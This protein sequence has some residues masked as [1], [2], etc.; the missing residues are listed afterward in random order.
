VKEQLNV[1]LSSGN[2]P[3]VIIAETL[4]YGDMVYYAGQGIFTALDPYD[5]LGYPNIKAA[6]D[7]YPALQQKT[8]SNDGK[9]YGL[10]SVNDCLHCI[11]SGGRM[12]YYIPWTKEYNKKMPTTTA[13]F[14]D[15]LR[16]I[17]NTD[18]NKNGRQDE[19]PLA[20][21]GKQYLNH[22]FAFMAKP[23][24]PFVLSGSYIG[25]AL[26]GKNVVEQYK[27]TRFRDSLKWVASLYKE[28]LILKD[29]FSMTEDQLRAIATSDTQILG[30][31]GSPWK[32]NYTVNPSVRF[33]Q[34]F[35]LRPLKGPS[36]QQNAGNQDPW[37]IAYVN[38]FVTDKC[39]DPA[40]A[41]ALYNWFITPD[42]ELDAYIGPKG[43]SWTDAAPGTKSFLNLPATHRMLVTY[44][45]QPF[46]STWD[47]ASPMIRNKQFRLGETAVG[48]EVL[49]KWY[50]T[51]DEQYHKDAVTAPVAAGEGL[52]YIT[53]VQLSKYKMDDSIFLPPM[54]LD[55]NDNA[56]VTD[57][58]AVLDPYKSQAF[59]EF[60]TGIKNIN[61]DADWNAYLAELDRM[62]SAEMVSIRQKYIK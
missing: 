35:E 6:F 15:Y 55:D 43:I 38:Y 52:W 45:T 8:R 61:S 1:L 39:K 7:E 2:Y 28:D 14:T 37:S 32:N 16:W 46:N 17:K 41:V 58:N 40:L 53:S 47:Q 5:P 50:D 21:E 4:G 23:F 60:V 57:I 29:S 13:E 36:G 48:I 49:Q 19:I 3:E 9:M 44:G 20:F 24:M 25:L 51:G 59:A 62:G 33:L 31:L 26:E 34:Y 56:R 54:A 18:L 27:D 22:F 12:W 10:P 42:V 30:V 11:Y